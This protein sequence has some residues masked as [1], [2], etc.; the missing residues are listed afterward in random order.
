[1]TNQQQKLPRLS[2]TVDDFMAATG[3]TRN[4]VYAAIA[5]GDLRTFKD[6]RRR[7]ISAA[8]AQEFIARRERETAEA[9]PR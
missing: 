1:M 2:Y 6:G 9:T 8:A 3:Y 4:R 5:C 7:M